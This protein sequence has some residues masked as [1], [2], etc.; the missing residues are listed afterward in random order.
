MD[1]VELFPDCYIKV[2]SSVIVERRS[3]KSYFC[4][5]IVLLLMWFKV[6]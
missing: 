2:I 3:L 5:Y 6:F 4:E 1:L